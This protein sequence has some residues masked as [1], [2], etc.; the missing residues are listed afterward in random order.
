MI[1]TGLLM[2]LLLVLPGFPKMQILLIAERV[3]VRAR[4]R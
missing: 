4:G 1:V 3:W 2:L